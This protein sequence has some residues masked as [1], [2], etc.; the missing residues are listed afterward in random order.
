[1]GL[2][3]L[4]IDEQGVLLTD[5]P[6]ILD[7]PWPSDTLLDEDCCP[8]SSLALQRYFSGESLDP[9]LCIEARIPAGPP[10]YF[11]CWKACRGIGLGTTTSYADLARRAGSPNA[12][13]A[14]ASSMRHNP[15]PIFVPCH[16]ILES[17]GGLGGFAG[18]TDSSSR[19]LQLKRDLLE[20]E[21]TIPSLTDLD[22]D[23]PAL[24]EEG[25]PCG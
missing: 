8:R 5:W 24:A 22:I 9:A 18:S 23:E 13:R 14:A 1:M 10:F 3:M 15:L 25:T 7:H 20:F 19:A 11:R 6:D 17:T 16:R 21:S 2:F 12:I 4:A